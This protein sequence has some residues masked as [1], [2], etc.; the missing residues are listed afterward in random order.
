[1]QLLND[2]VGRKVTIF[3]VQGQGERQDVGTLEAADNLWLR[4]RKGDEVMYFCLYHVR[5]IKPFDAH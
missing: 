2:L 4:L 5:L 1:M 3:S